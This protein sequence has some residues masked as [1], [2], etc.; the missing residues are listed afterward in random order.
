MPTI[1]QIVVDRPRAF[2]RVTLLSEFEFSTGGAGV[3]GG[4]WE[5]DRGHR[6]V[7]IVYEKNCLHS[8]ESG[9]FQ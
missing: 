4:S 5:E 7:N 2:L 1:T 3:P 6:S 9:S 8:T